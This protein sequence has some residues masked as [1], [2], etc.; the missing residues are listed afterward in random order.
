M[1]RPS[2]SNSNSS[3]MSLHERVRTGLAQRF[4]GSLSNFSLG[5]SEADIVVHQGKR[6]AVFEVKTG[7]PDLPLPSST[8]A[9]MLLLRE[10]VRQQFPADD[11]DEI[12]PV[13]IT[14]YSVSPNDQK[15]LED[16]GIKVIRIEPSTSRNYDFG[17]FSRQVANLTGLQ[18]D[19]I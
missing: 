10:Q 9:Q 5:P 3:G 13:V 18:A 7:D 14:N 1:F 2:N 15:V 17:K 16:Q 4:R 19:L 6:V 8:S 11:V 12:L